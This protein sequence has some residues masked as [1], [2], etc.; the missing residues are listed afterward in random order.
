MNEYKFEMPSNKP[1]LEQPIRPLW[2]K[3]PMT[4]VF[5]DC[6]YRAFRY[7]PNEKIFVMIYS[8]FSEI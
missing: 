6:R 1:K 8:T 4:M 7:Y 5:I 3:I 2:R